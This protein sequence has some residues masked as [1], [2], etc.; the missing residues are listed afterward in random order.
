MKNTNMILAGLIVLVIIFIYQT[1]DLKQQLRNV[2]VSQ[3]SV[4][5]PTAFSIYDQF[6]TSANP[7]GYWLYRADEQ[8]VYFFSFDSETKEIIKYKKS[9]YD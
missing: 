1:L 8:I 2:N 3:P 5:V 4:S 6:A 7:D 9:I